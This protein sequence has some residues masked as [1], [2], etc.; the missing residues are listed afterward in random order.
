MN[1][2]CSL[3]NISDK[4]RWSLDLRWYAGGKA[5]GVFGMKE[6]VLLRSK[7]PQHKIDW[8]PFDAVD[9][10]KKAFEAVNQVCFLYSVNCQSHI[11]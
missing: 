11:D 10:H 8:E 9:R 1:Y 3:P 4:V 7:N 5:A 2:T 6:G